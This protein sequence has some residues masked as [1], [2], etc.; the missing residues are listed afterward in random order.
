M[1]KE[2]NP[3]IDEFYKGFFN[4]NIKTGRPFSSIGIDQTC[5]RHNKIVKTDDGAIDILEKE[6]AL[7][8][9]AVTGP[10]IKDIYVKKFNFCLT[11]G[12]FRLVRS[13]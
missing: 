6:T 9:W 7:I 13:G 12:G 10:V 1:E 4:V 8:R 5:E 2:K 3:V 11:I